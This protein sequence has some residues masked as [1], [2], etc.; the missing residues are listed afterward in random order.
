M[1][2]LRSQVTWSVGLD[3]RETLA[4]DLAEIADA[5]EG[6]WSSGSDDGDDDL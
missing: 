2:S 6:D 3:D 4:N 1:K 5:Y